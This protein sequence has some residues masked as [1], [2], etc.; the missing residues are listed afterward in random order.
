MQLTDWLSFL[1]PIPRP[2]LRKKVRRR[3]RRRP[4]C[5]AQHQ[6]ADTLEQR[7]AL[8]EI[9]QLHTLAAG[10]YLAGSE[11]VTVNFRPA[12]GGLEFQTPGENQPTRP[13]KKKR[14]LV[15]QVPAQA[16]TRRLPPL[17]HGVRKPWAGRRVLRRRGTWRTRIAPCPKPWECS[18]LWEAASLAREGLRLTPRRPRACRP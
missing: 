3:H 16:A 14:R 17:A 12:G 2:R 13:G 5:A 4:Q 11:P 1:R 8:G 15:R 18:T 6:Y 10:T 9:F 7:I